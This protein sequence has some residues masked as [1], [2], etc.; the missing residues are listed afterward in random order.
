MPNFF[1]LLGDNKGKERGVIP[2]CLNRC[3]PSKITFFS[4]CR[5]SGKKQVTVKDNLFSIYP[6]NFLV[7]P[8]IR[9]PFA[10]FP[11]DDS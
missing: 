11:E 6:L 5:K 10:G 3:R 4:K 8:V 2:D 7:F 1:H 9:L